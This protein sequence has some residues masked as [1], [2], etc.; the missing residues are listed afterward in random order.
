MMEKTDGDKT[1]ELAAFAQREAPC[2]VTV[3]NLEQP[4]GDILLMSLFLKV[5]FSNP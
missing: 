2:E 5:E 1:K 3:V 4:D